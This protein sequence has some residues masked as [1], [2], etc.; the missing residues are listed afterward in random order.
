ML[1]FRWL[2]LR[3]ESKFA[4]S[5]VQY[6]LIASVYRSRDKEV[7][8]ATILFFCSKGS[9]SLLRMHEFCSFFFLFF[10]Q[11]FLFSFHFRARRVEKH[12]VLKAKFIPS[13]YL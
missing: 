8:F 2:S 5:L 11:I 10:S 4:D 9:K 12:K 6:Y 13:V 3:S 1:H 7:I